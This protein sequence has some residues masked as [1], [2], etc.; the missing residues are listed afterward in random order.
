MKM[1]RLLFVLGMSALMVGCGNDMPVSDIRLRVMVSPVAEEAL[2]RKRVYPGEVKGRYET[3]LSFQVAGKVRQRHVEAG[4]LVRAGDVLLELD[5]KDIEES[6]N[7][8]EANLN[9]AQTQRDLAA[10][11]FSRHSRLIKVRAVSQVNYDQARGDF[12]AA[13]SLLRQA[14]SQYIQS[15]NTAG[16]ASL[17]ADSAGVVSHLNVEAGTV[18]SPGQPVLTLVG[19]D[20][21]DV[22]I[23]VPESRISE[24]GQNADVALSFWA[25]PDQRMRGTVREIAPVADQ[26]TRTFRVRVTVLDPPRAL[27]LGMSAEVAFDVESL[28]QRHFSVPAT[29]LYMNG[30]EAAV[31]VVRQ[32][33]AVLAPVTV[34]HYGNDVV[35]VS[36]PLNTGDPIVIRGVHKLYEGQPIR[37]AGEEFAGKQP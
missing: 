15:Q 26:Q 20:N 8:A 14:R 32:G 13:E 12:E 11:N 30:S 7:I 4:Q 23:H 29:A 18:V 27:K 19:T 6:L 25:L 33:L 17:R 31:W 1:A 10:A 35:S 37:I 24:F 22:E 2:K 34:E 21:F 16:Y 9:Q 5:G 28:G 3:A 36:G